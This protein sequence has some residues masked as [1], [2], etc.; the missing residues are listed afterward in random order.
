MAMDNQSIKNDGFE[1]S[2]DRY[3][4][5]SAPKGGMDNPLLKAGTSYLVDGVVDL[6]VFG[7]GTC[8]A[9]DIRVHFESRKLPPQGISVLGRQEG[10]LLVPYRSS[11]GMKL[12]EVKRGRATVN[13]FIDSI[14]NNSGWDTGVARVLFLAFCLAA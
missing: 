7:T 6:T 13:E 3:L 12:L 2:G 11:D 5:S 1:K 4:Y 8:D 14:L 9:G 10:N